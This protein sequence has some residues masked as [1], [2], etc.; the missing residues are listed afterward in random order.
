MVSQNPGGVRA[1]TRSG[2]VPVPGIRSK[3][4]DRVGEHYEARQG[5]VIFRHRRSHLYIAIVLFAMSTYV[6][7]DCHVNVA[8]RLL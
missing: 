5:H 3:K 2:H 1:R 4:V 6:N 7:C 8:N